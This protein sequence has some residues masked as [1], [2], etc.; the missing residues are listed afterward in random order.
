MFDENRF[1][2]VASFEELKTLVEDDKNRNG[3]GAA[4]ANR[5]PI[6]FV[7]FDNFKDSYE[8]VMY[9]QSECGVA[10]QSVDKWI[11]KAYPDLM[12]TYQE[13]SEHISEYIASLN[14][15]D[16]VITPFSELARFYDNQSSH[17]FDAL[18]KTLKSI[19]S[20]LAGV[21]RSQRIYIPIIGLE[22]KMS[23][24][25]N[26]TQIYVWRLHDE[27]A[28]AENY[29]MILAKDDSCYGVKNVEET[30]NVVHTVGEWHDIWKNPEVHQRRTIV[31][32]SKSIFANAKFAQPDNAFAY[33][34][35]QNAYE[36][37]KLGL[38]LDFGDMTYHESDEENWR[39]LAEQIDL[40]NEFELNSFV[41]RYF[42]VNDLSSY[43]SF[44]K[45]WF[46]HSSKF[47]RW[48]L[49]SYYQMSN[50][51]DEFL[52]TCLSKM[53]SYTNADLFTEIATYT[54]TIKTEVDERRYC[55]NEAALNHVTLTENVEVLIGKRLESV[56][57]KFGYHEAIK[58]FSGITKKEKELAIAWLGKRYIQVNEVKAFFP[59]LFNYMQ[60]QPLLTPQNMWLSSYIDNYKK[61]KLE[62]AYTQEINAAIAEHNADSVS[63]D[64]WYQKLKTTGALLSNRSDI[65]VYY[66]IDGLGVEWIPFVQAILARHEADNLYLNET[67]VAR[68]LLPTTT[69]VNKKEL[70]RLSDADIQTMKVGDLD[71]LAH[72]QG[73]KYPDTIIS[74]MEIVKNA[75]EKIIATY[76]G[77]KIAIVSDHGLTYLSQLREGLNLAGFEPDHHGRLAV[78]KV[79]K[80]T[81]D[82]NYI[83]LEDGKTV[84]ALTHKSL[85]NKVPRD[86]G[87]HGGCTPEEVL[88]PIF[89]ISSNPSNSHCSVVLLTPEVSATEPVVRL[90]LKG[91]SKTDTPYIIYNNKAY[92]LNKT[93]ED[94]FTSERLEVDENVSDIRVYVSGTEIDTLALSWK[95]GAQ[96]NDLFGDF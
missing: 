72:K 83:V 30:A 8:F 54:T 37:L 1:K 28:S 80:A 46:A 65:E 48:L 61:A 93:G 44:L 64:T 84:C 70:Q 58:Y 87:I 31:S 50:S 36:F 21:E 86:Q 29:T 90:Q 10:I 45:V 85:C 92:L 89:V 23:A 60:S 66:W 3:M 27:E 49:C 47:D 81:Q 57:N 22:G 12:I 26:D 42:D 94:V 74:E 63:F 34:I 32:T 40:A 79:G 95:M 75:V 91:L 41:T 33:V 67:M 68:A 11:D 69:E 56:A 5:Y 2:T 24:F 88:V 6:R 77:K 16:S 14:G 18:I 51:V 35:P 15:M 96:E 53:R 25:E 82:K 59:D 38:R 55:L 19:E 7:L 73:N 71:A 43:M 62:N 39:L 20:S 78:C 17:T 52:K 4:T 13:L 9:M 76:A